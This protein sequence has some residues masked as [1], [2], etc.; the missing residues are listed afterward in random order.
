MPSEKSYYVPFTEEMKKDYTILAPN[1]LTLHFRL[2]M[3]VL[4]NHGYHMELLETDD[5]S[6]IETGLRYVHNDTCY[7]AILVIGQFIS[8]IQS[9]RYDPHKVALIYFQTGGGC[10][11][12]NYINLLRKALAKAGYEYVP[13]IS[14][15]LSALEKHPGFRLNPRTLTELIHA[16]LFGDLL[17]S[18]RNQCKPY[19]LTPGESDALADRI[20][21]ELAEKM[22]NN[23]A[24]FAQTRAIFQNILNEFAAIPRR[25]EKKVRVGIVGEIY[26]KFSPLGNNHLEQLLVDEG[27]EVV[28]PGL[29]DFLTFGVYTKMTDTKLYG[30][31]R[32]RYPFMLATYRVLLGKQKA[33]I[34]VIQKDGRFRAPTPFERIAALSREVIDNG[35]KMGEGWLLPAEML[36]LN[37]SGVHNVVCAQPFGCLPNHIVGKGM[38][39]P[40]KEKHPEINLVAI[41]YDSGATRVNQENRIRLMLSNAAE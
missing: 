36:E 12:S 6:I 8:A 1:M 22:K 38:M 19:E 13:V 25:K 7:P 28:T 15:S 20:T 41:D 21:Y 3:Q 39:K 40:I 24:Y 29:F 17:M 5:S 18:L 11:A 33:L 30:V 27:A 10:R 32:L 37:D 35:V 14:M 4:R 9:G 23:P 31:S 16:V 2:L 26:V 34:D